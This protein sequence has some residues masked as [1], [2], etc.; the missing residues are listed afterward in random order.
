ME[1]GTVAYNDHIWNYC[2]EQERV[3]GSMWA[4]EEFSQIG[5][6]N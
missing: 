6:F 5:L 1:R 3:W 4:W 2:V